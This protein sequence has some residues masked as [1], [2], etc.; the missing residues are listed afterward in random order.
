M[1]DVTGL[2]AIK[3]VLATANYRNYTIGN[4]ASQLGMWV[5]RIA[6]AWLTWELT[7]SPF[8]LGV[9]AMADFMPN[10]FLAPLAGALADRVDRLQAIRLYMCISAAISAAIAFLVITDLI[11]IEILLA[12]VLANGI[13]MSFNFPV[14]LSIIHSLVR[15]DALTTAISINAIA[16][17]V[18]RIGGPALSGQL[19]SQLG[20][21]FAVGFTVFADLVFVV[22]LYLVQLAQNSNK[23]KKEEQATNVWTDI[24]EGFKYVGGHPGIGP[25]LIVLAFYSIFGR[26]FIEL[27]PA[28]ADEI[29]DQGVNGLATLTSVLGLGSI[30]G[31]LF[32]ARRSGIR[33]LTNLLIF[34]V[35]LLSLSVIGFGSTSI[36]LFALICTFIGGIAIVMIGVIEQTLLQSAVDDAMRGRI[37]SF[38]TLIARGCPSIG[39]LGAGAL[40][41]IVGLQLSVIVG[42][43]LCVVLW[44]WAFMKRNTLASNL[45]AKPTPDD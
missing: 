44:I 1:A 8:W 10:I 42:A 6:I 18:A 33:G 23:K 30:V 29:F 35:L 22:M 7:K 13:T 39:A 15:H 45:E 2:S 16:F 24:L 3:S 9:M 32:L 17:N 28:F 34:N 20:I 43:F 26:P 4:F 36:Y 41:E 21:G 19:I 40:A 5:Q 38:Y 37:L 25:L 11:T 27:F 14:R 31:S 12:L